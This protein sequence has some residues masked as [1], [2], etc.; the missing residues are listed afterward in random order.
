MISVVPTKIY[1]IWNYL[2]WGGAQIYFFG[3]MKRMNQS[4]EVL[5]LMPKNSDAQLL[6]FLD[7]LNISCE[8]FDR[9][10]DVKP[11]PTIIRKL[12]RHWNKIVSEISLISYLRR[13]DF[14]QSIV[15]VELAPWQSA[16]ALLWLCRKAKV[17][18]TIHN[19]ILPIPLSRRLLWRIKFAIL[20][21]QKNFHIFTA[22][23]NAKESLRS[24]VPKEFYERIKVT[25]A[26]INPAEIDE[27]LRIEINKEEIYKKHN[28]PADKFLVFCVGQFIDRKG[29]WTFLEAAREILKT[30]SDIG[31]VWISNTKLTAKD[32]KK[33]DEYNLGDKFVFINS[34]QIGGE[35]ID[36][37]KLLRA[38]A[39]IFA[40]PSY[41]EGLPISLLEAMA[42][43]IPCISTDINGI[44][45]AIKHLKSGILIEAGNGDALKDAILLL[46][47]D[48]ALRRKLSKNGREF[49]LANF[50]EPVV[51]EIAAAAYAESFRKD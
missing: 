28:L 19:S 41:I 5:A 7:N 31:F 21:R 49:V 9:H 50:S 24:L 35:H 1:Y 13:F 4:S 25:Y 29:R 33:I 17:F 43:E 26:N 30:E 47:N 34:A 48:V 20:A 32:V 14:S 22:N 46:K 8:F 45:E 44:P 15:H 42:L 39:D 38:A 23:K 18:V 40:L 36:L 37:F 3:L 16:A 11:A 2:E 27:A 12:Q 6:K 51:A 10:A